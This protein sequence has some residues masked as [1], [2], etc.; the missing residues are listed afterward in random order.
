M[1]KVIY[2]LIV[3]H[4]VFSADAQTFFQ[5]IEGIPLITGFP[6]DPTKNQY[7]NDYDS[8]LALKIDAVIAADLSDSR[9]Y[10]FK[11]RNLK[12][13]PWQ[14][15]P[16]LIMN[17]DTTYQDSIWLSS[18]QTYT[19]S[20]YTRW[21][22]E[23]T[24]QQDGLATLEHKSNVGIPFTEGN[25][26]GIKTTITSPADTLIKGPGYKQR[27]YYQSWDTTNAIPYRL[28]FR[29]KLK[30][31]D[32]Y[33]DSTALLENLQTDI[34]RLKV[35]AAKFNEQGGQNIVDYVTVAQDTLKR[36]DFYLNQWM[37]FSLNYFLTGLYDTTLYKFGNLDNGWYELKKLI[38]FIEFKVHWLG[39]NQYQ[40]FVDDILVSDG[41]GRALKFPDEQV[42]TWIKDVS[43]GKTWC[44]FCENFDS[45]VVGFMAYDEPESIDQYEP[46]RIV[47][48]I[49]AAT[50]PGNRR[51][52]VSF[53][54]S[55][56]G[57]YGETNYGAEPVGKFQ[58]FYKRTKTIN[59]TN[60][61]SQYHYP[62]TPDNNPGGGD[63]RLKNIDHMTNGILDKL[64]DYTDHPFSM[65]LQAGKVSAASL[66]HEPLPHQI[67][68]D[69]N[70]KMMY[71]ASSL[72]IYRY[73]GIDNDTT[74][75]GLVNSMNNNP[76]YSPRYYFIKNILG[77]RTSGLFG[78][79]LK[80]AE[81]DT[82]FAGSNAVDA[83]DMEGGYFGTNGYDK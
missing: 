21:E 29:L 7:I 74:E 14:V 83:T 17:N 26:S 25:I 76:E 67:L 55:W 71:G 65:I 33:E 73:Y 72:F 6:H 43:K 56:N 39:H 38:R 35:T 23:G 3:L 62:Y 81:P 75:T 36:G 53:P 78:K 48:S 5:N 27:I 4:S 57:C 19:N 54:S 52:W 60:N 44:E 18:I 41:R 11:N 20:T 45:T 68:Y 58:E 10:E 9:F 40:L 28:D 77:P 82:Q 49:L 66:F 13:I 69:A 80:T 79:T 31:S 70:L 47:D 15:D 16:V 24:P 30:I 46:Y 8:L 2:T 50:P 34:C 64:N 12:V 63:Y 51:L 32:G 1:K 61:N 37:T 59:I 42:H 22:A